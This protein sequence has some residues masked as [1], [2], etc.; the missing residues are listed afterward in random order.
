M[1]LVPK[2]YCLYFHFLNSTKFKGSNATPFIFIEKCRWHP[3]VEPFVGLPL[4]SL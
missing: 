4:L 1:Y 2:D 3:V